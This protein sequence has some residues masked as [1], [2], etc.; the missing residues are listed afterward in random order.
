MLPSN[1]LLRGM[2]AVTLVAQVWL[3]SAGGTANKEVQA[4][5]V[6]AEP[7]RTGKAPR[8]KGK[9]RTACGQL[10]RA[11]R[12]TLSNDASGPVDNGARANSLR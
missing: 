7:T 11:T 4:R 8:R 5:R 1:A 6:Q 9:R 3:V 2:T 12:P 10:Q